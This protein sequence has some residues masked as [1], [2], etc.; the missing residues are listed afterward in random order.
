MSGTTSMQ[1]R[2]SSVLRLAIL[3]ILSGSVISATASAQDV[4]IVGGDAS[5]RGN[6]YSIPQWNVVGTGVSAFA[7]GGDGGN[8]GGGSCNPCR[9]GATLRMSGIFAG[10]ALGSG[11][12]IVNGVR[13]GRVFFTGAL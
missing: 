3:V 9:P 8:P 1:Q 4:V 2:R 12:A 5:V 13:Y 11:T 7:G 6:A 10:S